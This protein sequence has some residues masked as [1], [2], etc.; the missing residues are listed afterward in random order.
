M[1]ELRQPPCRCRSGDWHAAH[2]HGG[3]SEEQCDRNTQPRGKLLP[4]QHKHHKRHPGLQAGGRG[5]STVGV[6]QGNHNLQA[7]CTVQPHVDWS[8]H[9]KSQPELC[10]SRLLVRSPATQHA[11]IASPAWDR[12]EDRRVGCAAVASR[13]R[14]L[15]SLLGRAASP[16]DTCAA[17]RGQNHSPGSLYGSS[18]TGRIVLRT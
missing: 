3:K 6:I 1:L 13:A 18:L 16:R 8:P 4:G 14:T 2:L 9:P 7:A 15:Q 10:K 11:P 12:G 17:L 5:Q